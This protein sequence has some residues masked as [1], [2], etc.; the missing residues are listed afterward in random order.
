M[1]GWL[2]APGRQLGHYRSVG[3]V[4]RLEAA[5]VLFEAL[6]RTPMTGRLDISSVEFDTGLANSIRNDLN[7]RFLDLNIAPPMTEQQMIEDMDRMASDPDWVLIYDELITGDRGISAVNAHILLT[8]V[9]LGVI[10]GF[11]D[12]TFRPYDPIR[13]QD[14]AIMLMRALEASAVEWRVPRD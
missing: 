6:I 7:G 8:M 4:S 9:D 1:W 13:R 11:E 14:L 3:E 12:G 2:N 10:S 5:I